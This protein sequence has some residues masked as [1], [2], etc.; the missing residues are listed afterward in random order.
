[1]RLKA[2]LRQRCPHC[3]QGRVFSG[4][5]RMRAAC[6]NCGIVYEREEGY[7]L[8]AIFVGY[9]FD[10]FLCAP[11]VIFLL[12]NEAPL[13]WYLIALPICLLIFAQ[14][15]FRYAR[16][17]WMHLDELLDPRREEEIGVFERHA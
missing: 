14:P 10:L 7:F 15:V 6:P 2:I 13:S 1:M 11:L 9:I 16:V 3:L 4:F 12:L 8:M 17:A 5:F